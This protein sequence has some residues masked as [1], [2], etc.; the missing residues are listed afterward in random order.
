MEKSLKKQKN[1]RPY[2]VNL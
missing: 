2:P 1:I